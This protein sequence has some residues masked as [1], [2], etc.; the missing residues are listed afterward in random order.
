[1]LCVR[2][3]AQVRRRHGHENCKRKLHTAVRSGRRQALTAVSRY[4]CR[5]LSMFI[6]LSLARYSIIEL[7]RV[8][9][10]ARERVWCGIVHQLYPWMPT[11]F[12]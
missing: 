11:V 7:W 12:S 5:R 2:K 8:C 3:Q 9:E 6:A 1:M 10:Q 4:S